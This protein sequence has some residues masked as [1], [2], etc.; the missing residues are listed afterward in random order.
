MRFRQALV[1][2]QLSAGAVYA[3]RIDGRAGHLLAE[4]LA[5]AIGAFL[6]AAGRRVWPAEEGQ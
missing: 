6:W 2:A 5:V 3:D 4:I 1:T